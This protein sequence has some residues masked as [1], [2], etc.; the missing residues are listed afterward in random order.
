[1]PVRLPGRAS[2]ATAAR[3]RPTRSAQRWRGQRPR[4]EVWYATFTDPRTEMGVLDPSRDRRP[5]LRRALRARVGRGVPART[6]ARARALRSRAR[7][8]RSARASAAV[9][10]RRCGARPAEPAR[11][12]EP[13]GLGPALARRRRAPQ[14]APVH[15]PGVG[16]GARDASGRPG[17]GGPRV[18]RSKERSASEHGRRRACHR[19]P[20]VRSA[21]STATATPSVGGGCTPS[22]VTGTCSRS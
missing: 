2:T 7:Q 21:T 20:G 22:S 16:V 5:G 8:R 11:R 19:G 4:L 9:A 15:V 14:P 12:D 10:R 1:M 13:I 18:H 3:C 6:R 17:R